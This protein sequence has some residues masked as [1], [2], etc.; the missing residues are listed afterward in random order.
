V[1][2]AWR[3][4][5]GDG[6]AGKREWADQ[7]RKGPDAI[8]LIIFL[9]FSILHFYLISNS[10]LSLNLNLMQNK[11]NPACTI[12]FMILIYLPCLFMQMFS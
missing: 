3:R 8:F 7:G 2:A 6:L 11:R 5:S 10:N 12:E 4:E 9:F 1:W